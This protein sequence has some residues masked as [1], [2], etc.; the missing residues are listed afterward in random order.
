MIWDGSLF[1][2]QPLINCDQYLLAWIK[3]IKDLETH[4]DLPKLLATWDHLCESPLLYLKV[5]PLLGNCDGLIRAMAERIPIFF[6]QS[7]FTKSVIQLIINS[8][9]PEDL[10]EI[11]RSS[12]M[13]IAG[14]HTSLFLGTRIYEALISYL[15]ELHSQLYQQVPG[16]DLKIIRFLQCICKWSEFN[17]NFAIGVIFL[18]KPYLI[19][20]LL[21]IF[22][23]ATSI[24]KSTFLVFFDAIYKFV[25]TT[26]TDG[27]FQEVIAAHDI[28]WSNCISNV[29]LVDFQHKHQLVKT[30]DLLLKVFRV[31]QT[32]YL[33]SELMHIL[34]SMNLQQAAEKFCMP[35]ITSIIELYPNIKNLS[36]LSS[37]VHE[38]PRKQPEL[39]LLLLKHNVYVEVSLINHMFIGSVDSA[40]EDAYVSI[41]EN[42]AHQE[43]EYV[44]LEH[45]GTILGILG[46][47]NTETLK[48]KLIHCI[49]QYRSNLAQDNRVL[50][51]GSLKKTEFIGR[52]VLYKAH[53]CG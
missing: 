31:H 53:L 45:L 3:A 48:M 1:F 28:I 52:N 8:D 2:S 46:G 21:K 15:S 9:E 19:D 38:N 41:L 24:P 14:H 22:C 36:S 40:K 51:D 49:A 35:L 4:K 11:F 42:L 43:Y 12:L 30:L 17:S 5:L 10:N 39:I 13:L 44:I 32:P 16:V 47:S 26:D 37:F 34:L 25:L 7:E 27:K 20:I 33:A 18:S 29:I 23:L 6:G 50:F